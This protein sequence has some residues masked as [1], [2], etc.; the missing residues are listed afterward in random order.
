MARKLHSNER[1]TISDMNTPK[2]TLKP[3]KTTAEAK[4]RG[5]NGGLA[6]GK[7]RARRKALRELL[8]VALSM[9]SEQRDMSKAESIAVALVE[10]AEQGDVRAFEVLRDTCGERPAQTLDHT[11]SDGS[12][13][14]APAIDLGSRSIDELMELTRQAWHRPS[15]IPA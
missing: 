14:P 15:E 6:S 5:R 4:K 13:S 11:S 3:C 9:P 7:A 1:K 10:R 12:M 2:G 8:E